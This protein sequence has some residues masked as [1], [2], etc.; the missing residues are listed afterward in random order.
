LPILS[1]D[2]Y[3]LQNVVSLKMLVCVK[4]WRKILLYFI[5]YYWQ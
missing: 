4:N 3:I 2:V 5:S 1:V